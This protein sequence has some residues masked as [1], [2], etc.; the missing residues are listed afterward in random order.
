MHG[1]VFR[2]QWIHRAQVYHFAS[3]LSRIFTGYG[4]DPNLNLDPQLS[5]CQ[6]LFNFNRM[7]WVGDPCKAL[8]VSTT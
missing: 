7:S 6:R 2:S 3:P 1:F 5:A 4:F 8:A